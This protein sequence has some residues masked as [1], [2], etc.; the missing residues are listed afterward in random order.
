MAK[1][2]K[3]NGV[4]YENVPEVNVPLADG[5]SVAHFYDT[6][7]D[8]ATAENILTGKTAHAK[9]G[10]VSGTMVDNGAVEM[11]ISTLG[12]PV[13]IAKGYHDGSGT[14]SIDPDETAK[15]TSDNI[16]GGVT[17]LGVAGSTTVM[18]TKETTATAATIKK[19]FT[20]CVKGEMITGTLTAATVS[21][22]SSTRVVSVS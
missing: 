15:I 8:T 6:D 12:T 14:V 17:V 1:N 5:S 18:E 19:G 21:Q 11:T 20:A 3:I 13:K 7:S 22:D 4:T 16:K 10:A 9:G 2:I